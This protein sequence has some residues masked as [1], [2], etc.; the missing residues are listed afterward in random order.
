[1]YF[2][3]SS[4]TSSSTFWKSPSRYSCTTDR[5]LAVRK[6]LLAGYDYCTNVPFN[7]CFGGYVVSKMEYN[8]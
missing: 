2:F 5:G 4:S 3:L 8:E 1:M 6:L 7:D